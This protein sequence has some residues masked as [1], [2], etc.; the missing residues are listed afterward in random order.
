LITDYTMMCSG[1]NKSKKMSPKTI[2]EEK[3]YLSSSHGRLKFFK[4]KF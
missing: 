2:F 3:N 4:G 1:K